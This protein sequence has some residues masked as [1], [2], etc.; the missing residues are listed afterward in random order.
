[1]KIEHIEVGQ[2]YVTLRHGE[3]VCVS[4]EHGVVTLQFELGIVRSY[5]A[6]MVI[7][8]DAGDKN[9]AHQAFGSN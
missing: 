4:K 9:H 3:G 2:R 6:E 8:R 5:R 7:R 1:M